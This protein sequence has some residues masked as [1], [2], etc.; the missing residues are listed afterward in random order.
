[1][2]YLKIIYVTLKPLPVSYLYIDC[3]IEAERLQ[4]FN[5]KN[6][7]LLSHK[8]VSN[9]VFSVILPASYAPDSNLMCVMLDDD[10]NFN[11][12]IADNVK[13]LLIDL[14]SFDYQNPIEYEL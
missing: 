3:D 14:I 2:H 12:V 4:V 8:R 13:P 7:N 5:R 6:G 11:A 10:G 9:G 1:M